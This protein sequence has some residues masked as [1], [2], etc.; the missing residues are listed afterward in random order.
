MK[1]DEIEWLWDSK[2]N[3]LY[4]RTEDGVQKRPGNI[5]MLENLLDEQPHLIQ[6]TDFATGVFD[7]VFT[8]DDS[9]LVFCGYQDQSY[10]IYTMDLDSLIKSDSSPEKQIQPMA[11]AADMM[12]MESRFQHQ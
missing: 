12:R 2:K 9:A 8:P 1:Q 6:I 5:Y 11:I 10:N 4:E 7:P 3:Q